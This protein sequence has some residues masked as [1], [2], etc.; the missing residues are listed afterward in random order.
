MITQVGRVRCWPVS[1]Q[2]SEAELM[3]RLGLGRQP[4]R[5]ICDFCE[6]PPEQAPVAWMY[7]VKPMTMDFGGI[8]V[9][10]DAPLFSSDWAACEACAAFIEAGDYSGLAAHMGYPA[11]VVPGSV[12]SFRDARIGPGQRL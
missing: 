7:A 3:A 9:Q 2:P 5:R 4:G 6:R 8:P 1:E 11:G 10:I 12:A